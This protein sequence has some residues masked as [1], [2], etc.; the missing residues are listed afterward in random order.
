MVLVKMLRVWKIY[1]CEYN[2]KTTIWWW[3]LEEIYVRST[4]HVARRGLMVSNGISNR[5]Y[6]WTIEANKAGCK[7]EEN[8]G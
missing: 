5:C 1:M 7:D 2:S 8:K 6:S 4:F 3:K